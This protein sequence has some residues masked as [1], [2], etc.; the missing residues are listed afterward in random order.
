MAP[1]IDPGGL[2]KR[3]GG[4]LRNSSAKG[5]SKIALGSLRGRKQ[6]FG[7]ARGRPPKMYGSFFAPLKTDNHPRWGGGGAV[8]PHL[9]FGACLL[10]IAAGASAGCKNRG[11]GA[12]GGHSW[13]RG[14]KLKLLQTTSKL[15]V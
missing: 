10:E 13:G 14:E 2:R 9:G 4:L 6:N 12:S 11:S 8:V 5:A 1:K 15:V 7:R 3:L